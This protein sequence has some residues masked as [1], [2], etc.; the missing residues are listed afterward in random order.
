MIWKVHV[1]GDRLIAEVG[2]RIDF[3]DIKI[4]THSVKEQHLEELIARNVGLVTADATDDDGE[5]SVLILGRQVVTNTGKRLD[6][7]AIDRDGALILVEVKRDLRDV[8]SRK[9]HGE[10]QAIRY[11]A[12]VAKLRTIDDLV[13]ELYAKYIT[14]FEKEELAKM[15]GGRSAPEWARRKLEDFLGDRTVTLN[16]KQRI[17]L[18]GSELDA[19]TKSAAAWLAANGVDIRVVELQPVRVGKE[20]F[21]TVRTII[22][23]PKNQDFYTELASVGSTRSPA[24]GRTSVTGGPR[25]NRIRLGMLIQRGK[26]AAGD[27]IWF[28]S[29]PE[30]R[31]TIID[32]YKCRFEGKTMAINDFA[33]T[34]SGWDAV[35]IYDWIRH[36]KSEKRLED[37]RIDVEEELDKEAAAAQATAGPE[38][39]VG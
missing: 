11:A 22:P 3:R 24:R 7:V 31:A 27:E 19:D 20:T 26:V 10:M 37:L 28:V 32:G 39:T 29:E 15:G 25:N 1:E 12:S 21:I 23:P 36:G 2:E 16:H 9:D 6:L 13:R 33:K 17:I 38:G 34:V 14:D 18:I 5:S 35:N 30:R 8:A 4:Q